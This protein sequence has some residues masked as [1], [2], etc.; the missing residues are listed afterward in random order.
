MKYD[1]PTQSLGVSSAPKT[2]A[3]EA[4]D[5]K[6]YSGKQ[7]QEAGAALMNTGGEILRVQRDIENTLAEAATM[8]R[9]NQLDN[10]IQEIMMHPE[11]GFMAKFGEDAV[12]A[13]PGTLNSI[14]DL[15]EILGADIKDPLQR[16][17]WEKHTPSRIKAVKERIYGHTIN[18]ATTWKINE[19]EAGKKNAAT[20]LKQSMKIDAEGY[21]IDDSGN[22][23]IS[24][25]SATSQPSK[26]YEVPI[27]GKKSFSFTP[28]ALETEVLNE[29][30]KNTIRTAMTDYNMIAMVFAERDHSQKDIYK[31]EG[32][33]VK[34]HGNQKAFGPYQFMPFAWGDWCKKAGVPVNTPKTPEMQ[35][36][37]AA[38]NWIRLVNENGGVDGGGVEK[39]AVAWNGGEGA[40]S[41][42]KA[43]NL[44]V[45][46]RKNNPDNPMSTIGNY[47][48]KVR[49]AS[50][51]FEESQTY[52]NIKLNATL[53][54]KDRAL[55]RSGDSEQAK[56]ERAETYSEIYSTKTQ[57][58]INN[59]NPIA[60]KFYNN[61]KQFI[62]N[63]A[64]KAKLETQF[65]M[66]NGENFATNIFREAEKTL[67]D[68]QQ[69]NLG[70]MYESIKGSKLTDQ[71]KKTAYATLNH[72][73][74]QRDGAM[75]RAKENASQEI[76]KMIRDNESP[77]LIL[78]AININR[79]FD[80]QEKLALEDAIRRQ[81][82]E[83][84]PFQKATA[85]EKQ[86]RK[87]GYLA[88]SF[89]FQE[90][91]IKGDKTYKPEDIAA[92][93]HLFGDETPELMAFVAKVNKLKE[94]VKITDEKLKDTI[95]TM[96]VSTIGKD[97]GLPNLEQQSEDDKAKFTI[98][99]REV[100][101]YKTIAIKQGKP[102]TDEMA[103]LQA[104]KPVVTNPGWFAL[105]TT[106]TPEYLLD[107][108]WSG[109]PK[110]WP[111][112]VQRL[113]IKKRYQFE[114]GREPDDQEMATA[115]AALKK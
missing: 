33:P 38:K 23:V 24:H 75:R 91:Y 31:Q 52:P 35:D 39:A 67:P 107:T 70:S 94:E 58:L 56:A 16:A 103:I 86:Q 5:V 50:G 66:K 78:E 72:L 112:E 9:L 4:P 54:D 90:D 74:S 61:Y 95:R 105:T 7:M 15:H 109:E 18:Q 97:L 62:T 17:L 49:Y 100:I 108:K 88:K 51:K 71:G 102:I 80:Q 92:Q 99:Q 101:K 21:I 29:E 89:Q 84:S 81:T 104:L 48:E 57:E 19:T 45:L 41:E 106:V 53:A 46:N 82:G 12:K 27:R 32:L 77:Q 11:T 20:E 34:K 55:G 98:L 47:R 8:K 65:E 64:D 114:K 111:K 14:R 28:R 59:N 63:P 30:Q 76:Y 79:S 110:T 3:F 43:G 68:N 10:G 113:W 60:E 115:L 40:L 87:L 85:E 2:Q 93:A 13:T 69:P 1:L 42:L 25:E 26:K 83:L 37:V 22:R 73:V 36:Y 96:N 6:D 44:D